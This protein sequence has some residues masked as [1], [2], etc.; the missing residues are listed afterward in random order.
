MKYIQGRIKM[1]ACLN[2]YVKHKLQE[3]N[4]IDNN[5]GCF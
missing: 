5:G 3:K 2:E 4:I 1:K